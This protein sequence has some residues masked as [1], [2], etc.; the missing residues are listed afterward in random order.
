MIQ[1]EKQVELLKLFQKNMME[2]LDELSDQFEEEGDLIIFRFFIS[3]QIPLETLMEKFI[4]YIHPHKE[5]I[6]DRNDKFF[7]ERD[8]IF[9][10]SPQEKVIHFKK[11]YLLMSVEDKATLWSWFDV[12]IQISEKYKRLA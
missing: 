11:L 9:G 3:E 2:F 12:F 5:M 8:N 6:R 10:S 4:T 1:I 7:L